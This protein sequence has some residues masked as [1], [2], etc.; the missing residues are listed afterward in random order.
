M[1]ACCTVGAWATSVTRF[2]GLHMVPRRVAALTASS[3]R[4]ERVPAWS[5]AHGGSL[6]LRAATTVRLRDLTECASSDL[7]SGASN[8][9]MVDRT[10]TERML[11]R[12]LLVARYRG[13]VHS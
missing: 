1:I 3:A 2:T 6:R 8:K 12:L 9:T 13:W 4:E 5:Q 11:F 10:L 7:P